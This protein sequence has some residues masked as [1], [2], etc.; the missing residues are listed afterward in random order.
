MPRQQTLRA[1]IDWSY[2]LLSDP[3]RRLLRRLSVFAGG[4]TLAAA[5]TVGAGDSLESWEVLDLLTALM[6]KS[7][8][9]YAERDGDARY[10]LLE[11]IR[12]YAG[13]RLLEAGE[14]QATRDRHAAFYLVWAE[15]AELELRGADQIAW[16][17]R[18]E[19]EHDNLRAAL[20]WS[21]AQDSGS[22]T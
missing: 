22:E 8:V 13:E 16:L 6:D 1:L 20:E 11:T 15:Q 3:E 17:D 12:Q 2:D 19:E 21:Q 7:L 10:R 9:D 14:V 18:F 5:E 4:W